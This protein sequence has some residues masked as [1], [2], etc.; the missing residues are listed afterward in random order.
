MGNIISCRLVSRC[1]RS[2]ALETQTE[3]SKVL[4]TQRFSVI[5]SNVSDSYIKD[6]EQRKKRG[7]MRVYAYIR[8]K[9]FKPHRKRQSETIHG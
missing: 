5:V 6:C 3:T 9:E 1:F 8:K 7:K 4:A 2:V